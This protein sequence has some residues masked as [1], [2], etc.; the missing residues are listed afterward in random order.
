MKTILFFFMMALCFSCQETNFKYAQPLGFMDAMGNGEKWPDVGDVLQVSF[1]R[2]GEVSQNPCTPIN[3]ISIVIAAFDTPKGTIPL[4][5]L[6]ENFLMEE[7]IGTFKI[8]QGTDK[9]SAREIDCANL[10]FCG[11]INYM[12]GD[13]PHGG[14]ELDID[15]ISTITID[16]ISEKKVTGSYDV[17]YKKVSGFNSMPFTDEI[18][19]VC[20]KFEAINYRYGKPYGL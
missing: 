18:H 12:H 16:E 4:G 3:T 2:M 9:S 13:S 5:R 1:V 11:G 17:Y 8:A 20:K 19:V 7:K 6:H 14:Y 15:K 10:P